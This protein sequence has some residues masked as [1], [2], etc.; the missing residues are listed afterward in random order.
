MVKNESL[1]SSNLLET[2]NA[3]SNRKQ[4]TK[5]GSSSILLCSMA[6]FQI[7]AYGSYSVLVRL[8]EKNGMIEFS[9]T[10][11]NLI[12]EFIKLI[13]SLNAFIFF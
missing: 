6:V 11:M 1:S 7:V 2:I 9:S 13:F 12:I 3:S 5:N 10:A 4:Q 8:C